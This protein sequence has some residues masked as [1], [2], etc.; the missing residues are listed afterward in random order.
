M[1][2]SSGIIDRYIRERIPQEGIALHAF[3]TRPAVRRVLCNQLRLSVCPSVCPSV[4]DTS[5][6]TLGS[7]IRGGGRLLIF[8]KCSHPPAPYFGPPRLLIFR[9]S[10]HPFLNFIQCFSDA[11]EYLSCPALHSCSCI[12]MYSLNHTDR[13][14]VIYI[15]TVS[16]RH[17]Q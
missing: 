5:S 16:H 6:H 3:W 11:R 9:K 7:K 12:K 10:S 15:N 2:Y 8:G 14:G 17:I 1:R 4:C 13:A